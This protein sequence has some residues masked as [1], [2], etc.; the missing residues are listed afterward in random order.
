M[1]KPCMIPQADINQQADEFEQQLLRSRQDMEVC[2]DELLRSNNGAVDF[3][4]CVSCN[5]FLG[6]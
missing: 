1:L 4:G 6:Q 2:N 3:K 5:S